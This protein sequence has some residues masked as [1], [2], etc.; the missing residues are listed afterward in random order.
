MMLNDIISMPMF[1]ACK[2]KM[3]RTILFNAKLRIGIILFFGNELRSSVRISHGRE[4]FDF[5]C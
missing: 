3:E 2:V 1:A 5:C 4:N